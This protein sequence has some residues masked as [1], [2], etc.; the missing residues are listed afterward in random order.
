[1]SPGSAGQ[2]MD[3][4]DG[5][6]LRSDSPYISAGLRID[7]NGDNDFDS[8]PLPFVGNPSIGAF[9]HAGSGSTHSLNQVNA[10]SDSSYVS[11]EDTRTFIADKYFSGGNV[12]SKPNAIANT[13]NDDLYRTYRYGMSSYK[14]PVKASG[15][16]K[17]IIY[18]I[19]PYFNSAGQRVFDVT[20]ENQL[21]IT[22]L[23]IYAEAGK[24]NA[25]KRSFTVD[26]YDGELTTDFSN[27]KN[28]AVV[29]AIDVQKL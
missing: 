23:D 1:M 26:V 8:T 6:K 27:T 7:D 14:F 2:G 28:Y 13:I 29:S 15:T 3:T 24:F 17:V 21:K 10:G 9:E 16:Y 22:D 12:G 5:Y 18:M 20:A 4:V 19:E 11:I 25:Y